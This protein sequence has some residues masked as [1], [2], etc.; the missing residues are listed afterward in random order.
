[1]IRDPQNYMGE[2][3]L[4]SPIYYRLDNPAVWIEYN[5]EPGEGGGGN[6]NHILT[7]T[8]D[9]N[10]SDYGSLALN[11]GPETLLAH[12]TQANDHMFKE[13]PVEYTIVGLTE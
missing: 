6:L 1:M 13:A 2:T 3:S 11:E 8:R 5:N 4:D 7:I 9:P 12:Y 10:R